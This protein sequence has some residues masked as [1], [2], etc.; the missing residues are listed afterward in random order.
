MAGP[1]RVAA[2]DLVELTDRWARS[3]LDGLARAE[4]L[5]VARTWR[6]ITRGLA[7]VDSEA[8]RARVLA[9]LEADVRRLMIGMSREAAAALITAAGRAGTAQAVAGLGLGGGLGR[10][11]MSPSMAQTAAIIAGDLWSKFDDVTRRV[12]RWTEDAIDVYQQ[13]VAPAATLR[14]IGLASTDEA[15]RAA[16]ADF[17][18]RGVTGFTDRRGRQWTIGAYT[19]IAVR[20]ASARAYTEASTARMQ[21][22]GV[23]LVSILTN[24]DAC[25][26][27][28][29]W[30]GKVLTIGAGAT[31]PRIVEGPDGSPM[32]ITVDGSLQDAR[33]A[34]WGHPNCA[35]T[36]AAYV[37]GFAVPVAAQGYDPTA[38]RMREQQRALERRKRALGLRRELA[39]AQGDD[40]E[41]ARLRRRIRDTEARLREL[42][43]ASGQKRRYDREQAGWATG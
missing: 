5:L 10:S 3:V 2:P 41:A 13:V 29:P 12:L 43:A 40:M 14:T 42:V 16:L 33:A 27:C 6:R 24:A 20:T 39:L 30:S 23:G 19:E 11:V 35:C 26:V 1:W 34:G 37:P 36:I 28:G 21:E 25:S 31:G 4:Q 32:T 18:E 7:G 17:L 38:E 22:A 15:R 8:E 9:A